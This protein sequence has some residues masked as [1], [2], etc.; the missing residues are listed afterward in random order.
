MS[1]F[2]LCL[3]PPCA[4]PQP[5]ATLDLAVLARVNHGE[6][7]EII[8]PL[9]DRTQELF[10]RTAQIVDAQGQRPAPDATPRTPRVLEYVPEHEDLRSRFIFAEAVGSYSAL[11]DLLNGY[12]PAYQLFSATGD[13][14]GHR[15]LS[16][17]DVRVLEAYRDQVHA[18]LEH[19]GQY[20]YDNLDA[21]FDAQELRELNDILREARGRYDRVTEILG[22]NLI[23]EV[24][25]AVLKLHALDQK[26]RSVQQTV[27]GI[28]LVDCELMFV[29]ANELVEIVNAIFS[30]VGNPHVAR[31]IDGIT[32]LAGRNLLIQVT[33][34]Y[35]YYGRQQIYNVFKRNSANLNQA[36]IAHHIRSEI[37]ALFRACKAENRL[38]LKRVMAH[39]EREFEL[40][41]E[42]IREEAE[43]IAIAAV[44]RLLPKPPPPEAPPP[45]FLQR[46]AR[47]LF[48]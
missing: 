11:H 7:V 46:V 42:A 43:A 2:A 14:V 41:V 21:G 36:A 4:A 13:R 40:S 16:R 18:A 34:F 23:H 33:S 38:V 17:D 8:A 45:G 31:N 9:A 25:E 47:W 44:D 35:A 10:A 28:F 37:R 5:D 26:I 6:R 1:A 3:S 12:S 30:A 39:A 19:A 15:R 22:L 48:R 24:E 20:L 27:D 29:P 32:L